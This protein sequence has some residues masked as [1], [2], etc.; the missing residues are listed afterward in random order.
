LFVTAVAIVNSEVDD[1]EPSYQEAHSRSDWPKWKETID[2]ELQNL[3]EA[4]T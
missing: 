4:G 1:I 2:V 3:D